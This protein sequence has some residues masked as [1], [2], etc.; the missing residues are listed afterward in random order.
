M[1]KKK[2]IALIAC[3][4]IIIGGLGVKTMISNNSKTKNITTSN[5]LATNSNTVTP[6]SSTTNA[7]ANTYTTNTSNGNNN[8]NTTNNQTNSNTANETTSSNSNNNSSA[9]TNNSTSNTVVTSASTNNS[10][11]NTQANS[12]IT[13]TNINSSNNSHVTNTSNTPTSTNNQ[14][15]KNTNVN[16]SNINTTSTFKK[17][18]HDFTF[19]LAT[20]NKNCSLYESTP[21]YG[22]GASEKLQNGQTIFINPTS[23]P[24]KGW[25]LARPALGAGYVRT[26][27]FAENSNTKYLL[28]KVDTSTKLY[29][30][31]NQNAET[32]SLNSKISYIP[33]STLVFV[34]EESNSANEWTPIF[35][36]S[37]ATGFKQGFVPTN[38]LSM[39]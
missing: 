37:S 4:I 30:Q 7:N 6:N 25:V 8:G 34:P 35:V 33:S 29:S 19:Y 17:L 36:G 20:I 23:S 13:N 15:T 24:Q 3:I 27:S 9:P 14:T 11:P 39:Y 2:L 1:S 16:Y 18:E 21:N 5:N 32:I 10:T 22:G 26:S 38:V 28:E 31:P 12:N